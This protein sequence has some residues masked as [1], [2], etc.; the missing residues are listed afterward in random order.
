MNTLPRQNRVPDSI[1]DMARLS[2]G[3]LV[4][5]RRSELGLSQRELADRVCAESGRATMTRHELSRYERGVRLPGDVTLN[6]LAQAL[7]MPTAVLKNAVTA[8]TQ[9]RRHPDGEQPHPA[10]CDRAACSA[11]SKPA[12][13][14]DVHRST[15]VIIH[16]DEHVSIYVFRSADADGRRTYIELTELARPCRTRGS[17]THRGTQPTPTYACRS[18]SQRKYRPLSPRSPT[19]CRGMSSALSNW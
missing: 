14:R 4:A 9:A 6:A 5:S 18:C 7:E 12:N 16:A 11:Y 15:P 19:R 17:P 2:F 1:V 8:T 13:G 3:H 10:W